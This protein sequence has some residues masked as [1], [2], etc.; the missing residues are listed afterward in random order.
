MPHCTTLSR[1]AGK[2]QVALLV[3]RNPGEAI[4]LRMD[5]TGLNL[6]DEGECKVRQHGYR[7]RRSWRKVRLGLDARTGRTAMW[8]E[9]NVRP[10]LLTQ[11]A[12]Q[13]PIEEVGGDGAYDTKVAR[14]A[15]ALCAAAPA[16]PPVD[17]AMPWPQSQAGAK[18]ITPP[19]NILRKT[20]RARGTSKA[21]TT[22]ARWQRTR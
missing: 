19:S 1:R 15:I 21:V 14:V 17:G 7:K 2:L 9:A 8:I 11:I 13:T 16:I 20:A 5:S 18:R 22:A 12:P 4:H 6:F 3:L 10:D